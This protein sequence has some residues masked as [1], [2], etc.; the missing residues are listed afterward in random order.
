MNI[1][2]IDD[3]A[4]S[5]KGTASVLGV[6]SE[7]VC[8]FEANSLDESFT[9]IKHNKN[10]DLV[11]LD[12]KLPGI[13]GIDGICL[14]RSKL[15]ATPIVILS[16]SENQSD[17]KNAIAQGAKGYIF[18][19][20]GV[21]IILSALR[22]ILSGGVYLP[23]AIYN[24]SESAMSSVPLLN[25]EGKKMTARQKQVLDLLVQGKSNKYISTDLGMSENTCRVHVAAVLKFL[26]VN[27]RTEAAFKATQQGFY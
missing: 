15:P 6:L 1:L 13:N 8:T 5:R 12:L 14:I 26:N 9:I 4:I 7:I 11:L 22:L 10:I 24:D 18:K 27:N 21:K 19:S 17:I 20:S 3:H 16:A 25:S 2:I 23:M